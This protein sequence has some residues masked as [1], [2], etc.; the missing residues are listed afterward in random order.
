[1]LAMVV[2]KARAGLSMLAAD[3][4]ANSSVP[5]ELEMRISI[6]VGASR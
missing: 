5:L 1:M 4:L 6:Y 3:Q 2:A